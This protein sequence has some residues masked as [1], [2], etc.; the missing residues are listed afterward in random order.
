[1]NQELLGGQAES[2]AA[3]VVRALEPNDRIDR[4]VPGVHAEVHQPREQTG[5]DVV[6]GVVPAANV[7][8]EPGDG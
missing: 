5:N 2:R 1:M 4:V 6:V 8:V 7:H 3:V